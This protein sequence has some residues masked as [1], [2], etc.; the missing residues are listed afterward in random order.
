MASAMRGPDRVSAPAAVLV[1]QV[2]F[3][4]A[5]AEVLDG[6]AARL[7][8]TVAE[9]VHDAAL[10]RAASAVTAR[11][12]DQSDLSVQAE[13]TLLDEESRNG[14]RRTDRQSLLDA[15]ARRDVRV[16]AAGGRRGNPP[17]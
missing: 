5:V 6:E 8:V 3:D 9:Y 10:M 1:T 7:G 17:R 11:G 16:E 15:L 12:D 13:R 2:S 14:G 4:A